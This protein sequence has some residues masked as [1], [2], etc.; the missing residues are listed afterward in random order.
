MKS[1]LRRTSGADR[2]AHPSRQRTLPRHKYTT[3]ALALVVVGA[4]AGPCLSQ[5]RIAR[6]VFGSGGAATAND[7][8]RLVGTLGQPVIGQAHVDNTAF[9]IGFWTRLNPVAPTAIDALDDLGVPTGF[10]LAQ[11]YPNP[12]TEATRIPFDVAETSHV[13]LEVFDI[14]GRR[15]F[16]LV[17]ETLSPGRYEAPLAADGLVSGLYLYRVRMADY[18]E[19]KQMIIVR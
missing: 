10:S 8:Y 6:S 17:D 12:F 4:T 11:N 19:A 1:Y 5:P 9:E 2:T 16:A 3:V 18:E 7:V 14:L 15:V 13:T